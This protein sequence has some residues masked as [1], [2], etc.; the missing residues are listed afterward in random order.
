MT[1]WKPK[2]FSV[3]DFI[4]CKYHTYIVSMQPTDVAV[5]METNILYISR[6]FAVGLFS[7]QFLFFNYYY[8]L[9]IRN[10]RKKMKNSTYSNSISGIE[11][12]KS[13]YLLVRNS[14]R[15]INSAPAILKV[16][17]IYWNR[18]FKA[19]TFIQENECTGLLDSNSMTQTRFLLIIIHPTH[20][21]K[22]AFEAL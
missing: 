14:S 22:I 20:I 9:Q 15:T 17:T 13:T 18:R 11:N 8:R 5:A 2:T 7:L 21:V 16:R 6:L 1:G 3:L 12:T 4:V 10:N 19:S